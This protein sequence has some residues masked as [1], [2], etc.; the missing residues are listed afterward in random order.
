MR[1]GRKPE[2]AQVDDSQLASEIKGRIQSQL[3]VRALLFCL[4]PTPP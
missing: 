3:R 2:E 4:R 1:A